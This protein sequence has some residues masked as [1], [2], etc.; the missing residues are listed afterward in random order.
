MFCKNYHPISLLSNTSKVLERLIYNKIITH[1][2]KSITPSQFGFSRNCST[3]QQMLILLDH[4]INGPSQTDVIY[5]D[6]SKAFDTVSHAILLNKLWSTGITGTLWARFKAYLTDR[7]QCVCI[8]NCYSD[9]LPGVPQG[10][11]LSP[12][13]FL[14]YIN[15]MDSFINHSQLLKFADDTKCFLHICTTSDYNALQEDITALLTWSGE[16]D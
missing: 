11:I 9:S 2:S 5:L 8:N 6:I 3:L 16:S 7:Y 13:L 10:S 14:I 1:I 4:I 12:M 15:D